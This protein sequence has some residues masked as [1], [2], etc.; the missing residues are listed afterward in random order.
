MKNNL[1]IKKTTF[2]INWSFDNI[3]QF[4]IWKIS[5][6]S[7]I[8]GLDDLSAEDI[9]FCIGYNKLVE[10]KLLKFLNKIHIRNK[11]RL[12]NY[13]DD[14]FVK[15]KRIPS[16][17]WYFLSANSSHAS[18]FVNLDNDTIIIGNFLVTELSYLENYSKNEITGVEAYFSEESL[19][20]RFF[21]SKDQDFNENKHS[22]FNH[23]IIGSHVVININKFKNNDFGWIKDTLVKNLRSQMEFFMS[24]SFNNTP[25]KIGMSDEIY[26]LSYFKNRTFKIRNINNPL[27]VDF[28]NYKNF[29][30]NDNFIFHFI[31]PIDSRTLIK[32]KLLNSYSKYLATLRI[33]II[34]KKIKQIHTEN[35]ELLNLV[36]IFL[37]LMIKK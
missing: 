22:Y 33:K 23:H 34:F 9:C 7:L 12:I 26:L 17:V 11:I 14:L 16:N 3:K 21:K 30:K 10:K 8:H 37:L 15:S 29:T 19:S 4:N 31:S 27:S 20:Y 24:S 36:E 13:D 18:Y 32:E 35:L 28:F 25:P 2:E 1:N 5:F 6:L